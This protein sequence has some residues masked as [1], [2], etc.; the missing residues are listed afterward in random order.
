[1][2]T[3]FLR[4]SRSCT[5]VLLVG[6]VLLLFTGAVLFAQTPATVPPQAQPGDAVQH[7]P[8][9]PELQ[10]D[11]SLERDP[12]LSPD[13]ADNV[14]AGSA[15]APV[16]K[17]QNNIYTFHRDVDEVLLNCTVVDEKGRLVRDLD[18][19]NFRVWE[20]GVP[21]SIASL[22]Q[23]DL[24]VSMGILVDNSGS[25]RDKRAAVN[26]AALDLVR[27]S[28]PQDAAFIVNFSDDA[29]IDQDFTSNVS[30]LEKGLKQVDS[31]GGTA[32]YDAVFASANEL[33]RHAKQPKQVLLII[34]DGE[35]NASRLTLE[36]TIR[37]VQ[38]LG[39]PVVYSIGLL[40]D[41]NNKEKVRRARAALDMLSAETGGIAYFP[42]SL[43]DVD[44]I[45]GEVARD[46]RNQ[47]TIGYHSTKAAG[48]GGYRTVRVEAEAHGHG[49]LIVRTRKGYYPK[50]IQQQLRQTAQ[51][52][53]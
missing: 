34:T 27:A 52:A 6:P 44:E 19:A 26:A 46:I 37:R 41:N 21:Q 25:M 36:Q 51:R 31:R 24:P 1:M 30:L 45:A 32:L 9:K 28:N 22:Q 49:K 17:T 8:A 14:P 2:S 23:Q 29:Y 3:K 12:I 20:D 4:Q 53:Q 5:S 35:D 47:Y 50:Q 13:P 11:L 18:R 15:A 42:K 7:D 43:E 10:P 38:N 39:G 48:L 40:F 33:A 16:Q